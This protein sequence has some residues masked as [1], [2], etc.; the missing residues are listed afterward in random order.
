MYI[1]DTLTKTKKKFT[2]IAPGK[3]GFY[4]CGPTMYWNQHIGNMRSVVLADF[5]N[6][7]LQYLGNEV[8][9]VRN[10]T[11]VGHLSGDNE[12]DADTGIDRMEKAAKRDGK[13]PEEIFQY[14][15]KLYEQDLSALNTLP[16][17]VAP[18]ATDH[19]QEMIEMVKTLLDKEYA[20]QTE[21]AIYFDISK[22]ED[23]TKLSGQK[24]DELI[25][26]TGHGDVVDSD[27]KNAGDFSLWFFKTGTHEHALQTWPN[28]FSETQGFPGWHIECSAMSKKYLGETFDIHMGGIEH[29]PIHHTNEIAQSE[30][31]HGKDFVSYWIHNEHLLVDNKKMSKSEG[32][33]YLVQDIV[34][35]GYSPL[36]LRYFFMQAHYRSKQNFTWDA[37]ESS[38][39]AR[40]KLSSKIASYA[41]SGS[42]SDMYKNEFKKALEADFSLPEALSVTYSVL[43]SDLSDSDKKATILDFDSVLGLK[44]EQAEHANDGEISYMNLPENIIA[45]VDERLTARAEK[46]W[47]RSD[48]IRDQ[49]AE[50]GYEV[51]D[52]AVEQKVFKK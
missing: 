20:Y 35:K 34:D 10:Y 25:S 30:S 1:F 16:P 40:S 18:R 11:D 17:S 26:G 51:K 13:N 41:D 32:T 36:D 28:P 7:S 2:P 44:L 8:T 19:I 9:F 37:L 39:Q 38:K 45:L 23:Y 49:L 12:G 48:E 43:S 46:D 4:Q 15:K 3:V 42:V 22:K 24:L 33:S 29:I 6:R 52:T 21:R 50:L 14:Y 27:K 5:M 31:T 47:A